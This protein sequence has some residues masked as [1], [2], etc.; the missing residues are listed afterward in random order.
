MSDTVLSLLIC[1]ITLA[2]TGLGSL[3]LVIRWLGDPSTAQ[4]QAVT[5]AWKELNRKV[6]QLRI[7]RGFGRKFWTFLLVVVAY[8]R[9]KR[10][11]WPGTTDCA[12]IATIGS[13]TI[14]VT[15][16]GGWD[17]AMAV[18]EQI[19]AENLPVSE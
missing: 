5:S 13:V 19:S 8:W 14:A 17:V 12:L 10:T 18:V 11:C 9:F 1:L 3:C 7:V 2:V 4:S 15:C 16:I 6:R